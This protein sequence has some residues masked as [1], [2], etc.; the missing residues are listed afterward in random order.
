VGN[1]NAGGV[2]SEYVFKDAI[3]E[4]TGLLVGLGGPSG[5]GKTYSAMRLATG[6]VG[7]GNKFA[8]IDTENKRSRYYANE[9]SFQ[10]IDLEPPYRPSK[11]YDAIR[12]AKQAGFKA[13]VIDS[14]SHEH[15][16]EGGVLEW[17]EEILSGLVSRAKQRDSS[18]PEWKLEER[19]GPKSWIE[20]KMSR[21][22]TIQQMLMASM[23]M[24]IIVC[25]RAEEKL[26]IK[27]NG[28]KTEMV[29]EWAPVCG[30]EYPYEMTCFLMLNYDNPGY[31]LSLKLQSQHKSLFPSDKQLDENAGAAIRTWMEN[32]GRPKKQD[33]PSKEEVQKR[34]DG[35]CMD[36]GLSPSD[37]EKFIEWSLG[38]K[39][40]TLK[41]MVDLCNNF[42]KKYDEWTVEQN[43]A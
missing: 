2:M 1:E 13:T 40:N 24:P 38:G 14:M 27:K 32:G 17:H 30:K 21:K 33:Q 10:V 20:P 36:Y 12:A 28:N 7:Q 11:Y 16:G 15:A 42:K 9:F 8:V 4:P 41:H 34:F 29:T 25:F 22:K 26:F 39:Q 31:P 37:G 23:C 6:I 19:L 18:T 3:W 5:S 35:L 43:A